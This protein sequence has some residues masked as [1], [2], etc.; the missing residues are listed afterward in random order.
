MNF[1]HTAAS[2]PR[3]YNR[4]AALLAIAL[5]AL[6]MTSNAVAQPAFSKSFQP[7]TI[8]VGS[9]SAL[10][11]TI[12]ASGEVT[13]LA[14]TDVLPAGLV[15]A[16]PPSQTLG[17]GCDAATVVGA[18][19]GGDTVN[20][21]SPRLGAGET[22]TLQVDVTG[23]TAGTYVNTSGDLTSSGGNSGPATDTLTLDES[24]PGFSKAFSPDN[25]V[26]GQTVRLTFFFDHTG[27][28]NVFNISFTD[29][30]PI[31]LEVAT[32]P[33]ASN[34]CTGTFNTSPG[35]TSV[36]FFSGFMAPESSCELGVDVLV[37]GAGSFNNRTS[38][39]TS[40]AGDL[41]LAVDQVIASLDPV[42]LTKR[43]DDP[44]PP[45]GTTNLEFTLTNST[46]DTVTD[47]TF[48]DDLDV[49]LSGLQVTGTVPVN[50]CGTGS[51][52]SGTS[53]LTF[54][55][56]NLASGDSCTFSVEVT[57][58][59]G[60]TPGTYPNTTSAVDSSAGT[61]SA[62]SDD[63]DVGFA[64]VL[65][66]EFCESGAAPT[67][68]CNDV[69]QVEG[70]E[71]ILAR[72][73]VTNPDPVN[74]VSGLTFDD[75]F[76]AFLGGVTVSPN[77]QSDVCGGGSQF[78]DTGT[79]NYRLTSGSL[80]AGDT[81]TFQVDVQLPADISPGTYVNETTPILGDFGDGQ[82]AGNRGVDEISHPATP[83]LTKQFIDPVSA[84]EIV[85]LVFTLYADDSPFDFTDI[86][87][88]DD[89]EATL[90]G[91]TVDSAPPS[92][93]GGTLSPGAG[94]SSL[95]L[96]GASVTAGGFCSFTVALQV[97]AGAAPGSYLNTTSEVTAT[98]NGEAVVGS[99]A[100]D[101]LDLL[102]FDF[103]KDFLDDPALPGGSVTL[104]F[105]IDNLGTEALTGLTFTDDLEAV[106]TGLLPTDTPQSDICGAGSALTFTSGVLELTGGNLAADTSCGFTTVLQV[107]PGADAGEYPNLTSNLTGF[108][109]GSPISLPG[110]ADNLVVITPL[111]LSK[112]FIEDPAGAG[113]TATLSF[114]LTNSSPDQTA[115][116]LTFTDDL[117]AT[118]PG[119]VASVLPA[120]DPCGAGS[121]IAGASVLTFTGGELAPMTFCTFEVTLSVPDGVSGTFLNVTSDLSGQIGGVPVSAPGAM[122]ELTVTA[123]SFTKAFSGDAAA[124]GTVDLT[125]ALENLD[126]SS[127]LVNLNFSDDLDA[128]VPGLEAVG[129][130]LSGCGAEAVLSG[131]SVVELTDISVPA[132]ATCV[133]TVNLAVPGDAPAG[134]FTN[135][136]SPL[137][138]GSAEI[139]P[140][141]TDDLTVVPSP[142]FSKV[143]D[144]AAIPQTGVTALVFTIDNSASS[145]PATD[146]AFTDNL[147]AGV[148]MAA[149][150]DATTDCS[151]ATLTAA[152]GASSINFSGGSLAAGATCTISV[153]V[154]SDTPGSY[155][156]VS[157]AL[158]SSLGDSG[159]ALAELTVTGGEFTLSKAFTD[160]V[161]HGG[162]VD[163]SF[164]LVTAAV[165]GVTNIA[166]TDD[167]EAVLPGLTAVG[168][169]A[170]D[171]C[172]AGSQIT[173]TSVLTVTGGEVPAGSD[174]TFTVMLEVPA[175]ASTE[176]YTNTTSM[177]SGERLSDD[178]PTTADPASASLE[179]VTLEFTKTLDPTIA[180]QDS[181]VTAT[182]TITNPDPNNTV[183][184][185]TFSDDL[186]AFVPG[187]T[188]ANTPIN[189]P[190]GSGS[191]V[192]GGAT[193][194][195]SGGELAGGTSCTFD[196][197]LNV[198]AGISGDFTNTT[199][200][201]T[202]E[203]N[204]TA[205]TVAAASDAL[206][207]AAPPV[208]SKAFTP[209]AIEA[210]GT[211]VLTF[212]IDNSAQPLAADELAFSDV[213]PAHVVLA[214][215]PAAA[216]TCTGGT[217]TAPAHGSTIA[218]S[219]GSI[220]A[221][222]A[223]TVTATVT[224]TVPGTH[225]NVSGDLASSLGNSGNATAVL[226]VGE[227]TPVPLMNVTWM[228][229]LAL[230]LAAL[231]WIA[232]NARKPQRR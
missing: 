110:A 170:F 159:E 29:N 3:V 148:V 134:L 193:V 201:L 34:T 101:N 130:S 145:L 48:T 178:L 4:A 8:G 205:I 138:A 84:G 30:L 191:L 179:V 82:V 129:G 117:E 192:D 144:P 104:S 10:V 23:D 164:T 214:D 7:D 147:P 166:F 38:N 221:G 108:A 66:K 213:L 187:M 197:M 149:S 49:T 206:T 74:A 85:D 41:G 168:L 72:F 96:T 132:A 224:S 195:L 88:S 67:D 76:F 216:T 208:F 146:L 42:G 99:P 177:A 64:P 36:A 220:A 128:V 77:V 25:I 44:V 126:D 61:F 28:A 33:D 228:A 115:T 69:D 207:V 102:F 232:L 217:L 189:D 171:F 185:L 89:L 46:R 24:R 180:A 39:A 65:V 105:Q 124:G 26:P 200:E 86:G 118:L 98:S 167:L 173:G 54:T 109:D 218:Y 137:H 202:S 194:T 80:A 140:P 22:C 162:T 73:S 181:T 12:T 92:P 90:A 174:C 135:T 122:D 119:L 1:K 196:V 20:F 37:T 155:T 55:G 183:S 212:T 93:C 63:L 83:R 139:A 143:F 198:P 150:P 154:T 153:D 127:A 186:D 94:G 16:A 142:A 165:T 70:G 75:D 52:I 53:L 6:A 113:G 27:P 21:T 190:C 226:T 204:A 160:P 141:A 13:D 71:L 35:A 188:A 157:G 120:G 182:F 158:T 50:P 231:G 136:S 107:P 123:A 114:T 18:P 17:L 56:G 58:P 203:V 175:D 31:G 19:E 32:A 211:S 62:A 40:S 103:Q 47:I 87:F 9:T 131:T 176:I 51:S 112:S 125:F 111:S 68:P 57:V 169:P 209:N 133:V 229:V 60:A 156:N 81:C 78:L 230:M 2:R 116:S 11:F 163:L 223:C 219:G 59:A 184:G 100:S 227:A 106:L 161:L 95:T 210:G 225:E 97:P 45:G 91:L 222:E 215:D 151:G 172:G 14:F 5:C 121:Q 199:S 15:L 152:A 43:F 79:D